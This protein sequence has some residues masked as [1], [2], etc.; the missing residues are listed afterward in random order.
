[1]IV[2]LIVYGLIQ[3]AACISGRRKQMMSRGAFIVMGAGSL[4]LMVGAVLDWQ[5][6]ISGVWLVGIG[7]YLISDSAYAVGSRRPEGPRLSHHIVRAGVALLLL[8]GVI[9]A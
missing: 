4:L 5:D 6:W 2:I 9:F 1:M 3:L 8:G 7:L